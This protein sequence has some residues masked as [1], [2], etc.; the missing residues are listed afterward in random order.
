MLFLNPNQDHGAVLT[1]WWNSA[2]VFTKF[3]FIST[4]VSSVL[5]TLIFWKI[6]LMVCFNP[7][8]VIEVG[9]YWQFFTFPYA[10]LDPFSALFSLSS[11]MPICSKKEN[12]LGT[13]RFIVYFT[14]QNLIVALTF[15]PLYYFLSCIGVPAEVYFFKLFLSGLWPSIMAEMVL[16]YNQNREE[17]TQ[18][19]CF[20]LQIQRKMYP[21]VFFLFFSL[22]FGI[23]FEL[24]AG[25]AAGYLCI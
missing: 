7:L 9:M 3:I 13:F 24:L 6:L 15:I 21:V 10:C 4:V 12:Q 17:T 1:N 2:G 19:M 22:L 14:L 5:S 18:F 25:L 8:L 11:Y 16:S 20:P 23:A